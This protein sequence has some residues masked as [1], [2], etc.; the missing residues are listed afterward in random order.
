MA[1]AIGRGPIDRKIVVV[2][3]GMGG[4]AA[5]CR[6]KEYGFKD[7]ALIEAR[8]RI[9]GRTY[10]KPYGASYI[11]MGAQWIH[12]QKDNVLYELAKEHDLVDDDAPDYFEAMCRLQQVKTREEENEIAKLFYIL[13]EAGEECHKLLEVSKDPPPPSLGHFLRQKFHEHLEESNDEPRM[14]KLKEAFFEWYVSL[15]NEINGSKS[16]DDVSAV[17]LKHYKECEGRS[18][19]ELK[20]NYAG[21]IDLFLR[22]IPLKWIHKNHVVSL[23]KYSSPEEQSSSDINE[24]ENLGKS[25]INEALPRFYP[26]EVKCENGNTF[27]ADHVILT[28]PLGC[29]KENAHKL[30]DPPLSSRKLE[31]INCLGFGAVNK[32]YLEFESP[33]WNHLEIIHVL[34]ME[35]EKDSTNKELKEPWHRSIARFSYVL[36]H[37]HLLCAWIGGDG[38]VFMESL[39][40]EEVAKGCQSVLKTMLLSIEVPL[41]RKII[42]SNWYSDPYSR[43][44]YT[45]LSV[46]CEP[47]NI[48][49][50][51][52]AEPVYVSNNSFSKQYPLILFAGEATHSDY[53][54]TAHGA[55]STGIRE[56]DRLANF[57]KDNTSLSG[58]TEVQK[59]TPPSLICNNLKTFHSP[60]F[61]PHGMNPKVIIIGAG[62]AGLAAAQRLLLN[63]FKDIVI[64]EAQQSAGGRIHTYKYG[65]GVLELGAQWVHGEEGNPLFEFA[66]NRGLLS[67]PKL[68]YSVERSGV[69]CTDEGIILNKNEVEEVIM[70]LDGIRESINNHCSIW[71]RPENEM[72][73]VGQVFCQQFDKYLSS[74]D[75]SEDKVNMMKGIFDWYMRFEIIDNACNSLDDLSLEG[76]SEWLECEGVCNI[77]FRKGFNSL[78][79]LLLQDIPMNCLKQNKPAKHVN[80]ETSY[81]AH[82]G[83]LIKM[84]K[85]LV[86]RDFLVSVECEDGE[87]IEADHIIVTPSIGYLK[88]HI[89]TFFKPELPEEKKSII[90]SLGFGT[91]DKIFLIFEKPFWEKHDIGFQLIW[92]SK[93]K[94]SSVPEE[95]YWIRGISGFDIVHGQPN[96]LVGWIGGKAAED[97]EKVPEKEVGEICVKYLKR[98]LGKSD[99]SDPIQVVKSSWY[100]NPFIL[101]AYSHRTVIFEKQGLKINDLSEPLFCNVTVDDK[102]IKWPTV[103]F[104]GEG[105]DHEFF[106]TVHGALRSGWKEADRLT[107]FWWNQKDALFELHPSHPKL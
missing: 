75:C 98:F 83:I 34:R 104:A 44:S 81:E 36:G 39:S 53:Y 86:S 69:F 47:S 94:D 15:Q 13:H 65:K 16:L 6:L 60:S 85:E 2:G 95:E 99:I 68:D 54:S 100:S 12:G 102:I 66:N 32:I 72:L 106:S 58:T 96:V 33:F 35:N 48:L 55:Y 31:A 74:L 105:T 70:V 41:P 56:A 71:P 62:T 1:R 20:Y 9:G 17:L 22:N 14:K 77:N 73:S 78:I 101:G 50:I 76:Y 90:E 97:M 28:I 27:S 8:D 88:K 59:S 64:L 49:P 18:L 82:H 46:A 107:L 24:S 4:L 80:W 19:V 93:T 40:D 87:I 5:V 26:L 45:Y 21:I 51:D 30:F 92:T 23:I 3:A 57:Y 11:E 79:K 52:L 10:S 103:L 7:V 29:L 89:N 43:G 91:I 84:C 61:L 37:P 38:A 25:I 42:R 67:N 63:G